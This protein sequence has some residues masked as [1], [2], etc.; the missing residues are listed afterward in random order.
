MGRGGQARFRVGHEIAALG[1]MRLDG[2]PGAIPPHMFRRL[3][4]A[5]FSAGGM[6]E[7]GGQHKLNSEALEGCITDIIPGDARPVDYGELLVMAG[8]FDLSEPDTESVYSTYDLVNGYQADVSFGIAMNRCTVLQYLRGALAGGVG[9]ALMAGS[10]HVIAD[11]G[12]PGPEVNVDNYNEDAANYKFHGGGDDRDQT[13]GIA[14]FQGDDYG[15]YSQD[16]NGL[17]TRHV[18]K[19]GYA[20]WATG[21]SADIVRSFTGTI[22]VNASPWLVAM[23]A[24]TVLVA[25]LESDAIHVMNAAGA[26]HRVPLPAS[27]TLNDSTPYHAA[28][29]DGYLYF[30][31]FGPGGGWLMY[32]YDPTTDMVTAFHSIAGTPPTR[33]PLLAADGVLYYGNNVGGAAKLGRFDGTTLV[34]DY[35]TFTGSAEVVQLLTAFA[36]YYALRG[37]ELLEATVPTF[38]ST[39][40]TDADAFVTAAVYPSLI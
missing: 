6:T 11:V 15:I 36:R 22:E 10:G 40:S 21:T 31:G 7:R 33:Q 28:E 26:W 37:S 29:L 35:F 19:V 4:N 1:G 34:D 18:V 27:C 17:I 20:P 12:S 13:G 9:G 38:W 25:A 3:I 24:A 30:T 5:R 14:R 16:E 23:Q 39:I 2:L 8:S 32:R